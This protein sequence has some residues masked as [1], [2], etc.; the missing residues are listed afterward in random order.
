MNRAKQIEQSEK[1]KEQELLEFFDNK[2]GGGSG[3][4][5]NKSQK[6]LK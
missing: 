5:V 3:S 2:L 1:V 6:K 4:N